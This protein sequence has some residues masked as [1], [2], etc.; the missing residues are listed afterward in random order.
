MNPEVFKQAQSRGWMEWYEIDFEEAKN[1]YYFNFYDHL[2]P[3]SEGALIDEKIL[4]LNDILFGTDFCEKFIE[5]LVKFSCLNDG[6]RCSGGTAKDHQ[7]HM[8]SMSEPERITFLEKH[9]EVKEE[10]NTEQCCENG[11]F[12]D[13]HI[14]LKESPQQVELKNVKR[15]LKSKEIEKFSIVGLNLL[16]DLL[17]R[18]MLVG[19]LNQ[20]IIQVNANTKAI[21]ENKKNCR[22]NMN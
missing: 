6:L 16:E 7:Y 19:K 13:K 15:E 10:K 4:S 5:S 11:L 21:D 18:Q 3:E 9:L 1:I 2:C 20:L 17:C 22:L 8:L 12:Q 14:C